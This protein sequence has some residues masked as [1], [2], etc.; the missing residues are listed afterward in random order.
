MWAEGTLSD[1]GT[2][3]ASVGYWHELLVLEISWRRVYS[4]V[5]TAVASAVKSV[6]MKTVVRLWHW[7]PSVLSSYLELLQFS[8]G[9][10]WKTQQNFLGQ[11]NRHPP[12]FKHSQIEFFRILCEGNISCFSTILATVFFCCG[13]IMMLSSAHFLVKKYSKLG[14]TGCTFELVRKLKKIREILLCIKK[15][16]YLFAMQA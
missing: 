9:K 6:V 10:A 11:K 2:A 15:T 16:S 1:S 13:Q 4:T 8:W 3:G 14:N 5:I 7:L 12:V